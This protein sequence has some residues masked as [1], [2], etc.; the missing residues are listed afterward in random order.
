MTDP[1][2]LVP[3]PEGMVPQPVE[4][5][6]PSGA[7]VRTTL[8]DAVIALEDEAVDLVMRVLSPIVNQVAMRVLG[9]ATFQALTAASLDELTEILTE[10]G[11]AVD[12]QV[13]PHYQ[14]V[15]RVGGMSALHQ[16]AHRL[17]PFT[18]FPVEEISRPYMMEAAARHLAVAKNRFLQVGEYSWI[19]ARQQLLNGMDRGESVDEIADNLREVIAVTEQQA[20]AVARTEVVS[21]A[22]AGALTQAN[23]AG[24]AAPPF[25]QWLATDDQRTRPTHHAADG[26]VVPRTEVFHVGGSYLRYPGD[27]AGPPE[28]TW[29]C[30]CT[31]LFVESP[32]GIDVDSLDGRQTGGVLGQ[33]IPENQIAEGQIDVAKLPRDLQ[34]VGM[35]L[36]RFRALPDPGLPEVGSLRPSDDLLGYE[37]ARLHVGELLDDVIA[38]RMR[39]TPGWAEPEVYRQHMREIMEKLGQPWAKAGDLTIKGYRSDVAGVIAAENMVLGSVK[40]LPRSWVARMEKLGLDRVE[41][42]PEQATMAY[43]DPSQRRVFLP[44]LGSPLHSGVAATHELGHMAEHAVPGLRRA[45]WVEKWHR[46]SVDRGDEWQI[47]RMPSPGSNVREDNYPHWYMGVDYIPTRQALGLERGTPGLPWRAEGEYPIAN[48]YELWTAGTHAFLA[49]QSAVTT[50]RFFREAF[51]GMQEA[52]LKDLRMRRWVLAM[53]ATLR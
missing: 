41:R 51:P 8:R 27:P 15:F 36:N 12:E 53:L 42:L 28:E 5:P 34:D 30:R 45:E 6:V 13:L 3:T 4:D 33:V 52:S 16:M 49:D 46:E 35:A 29:N 24:E 32:D 19:E 50:A 17:P 39:G 26:Q 48:F 21:A 43:Y 23:L 31:I 44:G 14:D 11:V 37:S 1:Q 25:K 9:D 7:E 47:L 22:N 10:W 2:I 40:N 38:V 20:R 18:E